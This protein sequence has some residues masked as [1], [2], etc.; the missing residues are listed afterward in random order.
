MSKNVRSQIMIDKD[1]AQRYR[2]N[3][4]PTIEAKIKQ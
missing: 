1:N 2:K 4:K 3:N